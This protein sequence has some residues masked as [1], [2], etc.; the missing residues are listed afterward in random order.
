M[1]EEIK[2]LY[3]D[4]RN[5]VILSILLEC[6]SG[7]KVSGIRNPCKNQFEETA[8]LNQT[9][10]MIGKVGVHLVNISASD[11]QRGDSKLTLALIWHLILKYQISIPDAPNAPPKPAAT[12]D[13]AQSELLKWVNSRLQ[14]YPNIAPATNFTT[15]FQSGQILCAVTD[16][17]QPG[18]INCNALSNHPAVDVQKA[19]LVAESQFG[20]PRLLD[21]ED[22]VNNTDDSLSMMAY[23]SYFREWVICGGKLRAGPAPPAPSTLPAPAASSAPTP[24][25]Q[26]S[27]P[28]ATATGSFC[29]QCG[30][31]AQSAFCGRCGHKIGAPAATAPSPLPQGA[32]PM[33]APPPQGVIPVP[34][35]HPPYGAIPAPVPVPVPV[36]VPALQAAPQPTFAQKESQIMNVMQMYEI[37][38]YSARELYQLQGFD[39]VFICDDSGSMRALVQ[40][41]K[42]RWDEL[43]DTVSRVVDVAA[44]FDDDGIDVYFLNR[45]PVQGVRHSSQLHQ[46]FIAPPAGYTPLAATLTNVLQDQAR[47]GSMKPLLVI[48]ATDGQPTDH[49][50]RGNIPHFI[51]VVSGA[52]HNPTRMTRF[53]FLACSD[54]DNDIAWLNQ[55]DKTVPRVDVTDDYISER[56]EVLQAGRVRQFSRGD[57]VCKALLGGISDHYDQMDEGA[58]G[59][60]GGYGGGGY[61]QGSAGGYG[62]SQTSTTMRGFYGSSKYGSNQ[63]GKS[64]ICVLLHF[65]FSFVLAGFRN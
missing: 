45:G 28:A 38:N 23:L 51:Q 41:G 7:Q 19:L 17:L 22:V 5:G 65:V 49:Q 25:P 59:G 3:V 29:G 2:D 11:I 33:Q 12:A 13:T 31:P 56:R 44:C 63:Y 16:S 58:Y 52:V 18:V 37:T 8:N 50:G 36:P 35:Q 40:G 47:R 42:T 55:V 48:I 61:G 64:P 30:A 4:M 1:G 15:S 62:Y 57:Y 43:R 46:A 34:A 10:D 54:D 32:A 24:A 6:L 9:F 21:A 26:P 20:I 27:A 60:Y 39:V 14:A 53:Q